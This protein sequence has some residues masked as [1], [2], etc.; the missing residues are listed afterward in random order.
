MFA[1]RTRPALRSLAVVVILASGAVGCGKGDDSSS[2]SSES[3][4]SARIDAVN[5]TMRGT[6]FTAT[7]TTTAF[8]GATQKTSWDPKQGYRMEVGGTPETEGGSMYCKD[9]TSYTSTRLFAAMLAQKGQLVT[10]PDRLSDSYVSSDTGQDCSFSFAIS[11]DGRFAPDKDTAVDGRKAQAIEVSSE[12]AEDVYLVSRESPDHLL[13]QEAKRD[14]KASSTTYSG[15]GEKMDIS[16]PPA[17]K[18]M[19]MSE[20]RDAVG[21]G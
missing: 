6:S 10:V 5:K 4:A 16:M 14:G 1:R 9:G 11:S 7:G 18:T 17:D 2:G 20:F 15:F 21:A 13:K 19:T 12:L 8:E 3:S